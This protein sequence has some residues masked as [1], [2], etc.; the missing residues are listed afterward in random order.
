MT[1]KRNPR[2]RQYF[3]IPMLMKHKIF[4]RIKHFPNTRVILIHSRITFS[5]ARNVIMIGLLLI[6]KGFREEAFRYNPPPTE[7]HPHQ[8]LKKNMRKPPKGSFLIK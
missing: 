5:V 6:T 8:K 3:N 2:Y 4:R 7:K 1:R